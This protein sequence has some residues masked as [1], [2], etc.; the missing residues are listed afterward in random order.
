MHQLEGIFEAMVIATKFE[1]EDV[2]TR[3]LCF[4]QVEASE[5]SLEEAVYLQNKEEKQIVSS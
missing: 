4:E 2:F 5:K 1:F 3:L